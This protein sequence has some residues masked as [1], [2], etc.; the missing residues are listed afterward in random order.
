MMSKGSKLTTYIRNNPVFV[1]LVVVSAGLLC[2]A[3]FYRFLF[4]T[5]ESMLPLVSVGDLLVVEK[6]SA[7]NQE[8]KRWDVAAARGLVSPEGDAGIIIK[9]IVGLPGDRVEYAGGNLII[10]G[11][12][13]PAP[14]SHD[15]TKYI[16][17]K[18]VC[19]LVR[20]LAISPKRPEFSVQLAQDEYFLVGDNRDESFD[21]RAFG[22]VHSSDLIGVVRYVAGKEIKDIEADENCSKAE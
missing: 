2:L 7:E 17:L 15:N 21:S 3:T 13:V 19:H 9:R 12:P 1:L 8:F 20:Y 16:F 11:R 10:N 4:V 6:K 18:E 5:S 22:A 14:R